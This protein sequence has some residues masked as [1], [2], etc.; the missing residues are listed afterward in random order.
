LIVAPCFPLEVHTAGVVVV[1]VKVTGNVDDA[2][3]VTVSGDV[4]NA[5]SPMGEKVIVCG[6]FVTPKLCVADAGL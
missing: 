3:A 6:A 1:T 2:V 5:L 4:L